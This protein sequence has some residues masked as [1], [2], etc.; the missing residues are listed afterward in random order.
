MK[1]LDVQVAFQYASAAVSV[2]RALAV[3]DRKMTFGNFGKAIGLLSHNERWKPGVHSRQI[4]QIL[5]LVA[6]GQKYIGTD[7]ILGDFRSERFLET[8]R[9]KSGTAAKK[10]VRI[11][12]K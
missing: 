3:E 10:K 4:G 1:K 2:C 12:T 7:P 5:D 6:A 8:V 11:V 9:H